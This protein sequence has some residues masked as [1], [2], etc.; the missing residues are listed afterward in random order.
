MT[1]GDGGPDL[2]AGAEQHGDRARRQPRRQQVEGGHRATALAGQVHRGD[3]PADRGPAGPAAAGTAG[4]GEQGDPRQAVPGRVAERAAAYGR[5]GPPLPAVRLGGHR[6]VG[7]VD[8][9]HR[10]DAGAS[11]RPGRTSPRRRCRRGRSVPGCPSRARR[12]APPGRAGGRRRAGGSSRTR[13]GGGRTGRTVCGRCRS[14]RGAR[15][16]RRHVTGQLTLLRRRCGASPRDCSITPRNRSASRSRSSASRSETARVEPA[17][18]AARLAAPAAKNVAHS[19][20][21][22]A[23]S[24]SSTQAFFWRRP[25]VGAGWA[26]AASSA[27]AARS[28][29]TWAQA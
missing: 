7:E 8:A 6:P 29:A 18:A 20:S 27:A 4:R 13:R 21:S 17:S 12:P 1:P 9:E 3:Q 5:A 11:G 10:A 24:A 14:A 16:G 15:A 19:A 2:G 26:R 22:G 25:R 23:T 28:A